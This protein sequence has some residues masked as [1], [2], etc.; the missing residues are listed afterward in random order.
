MVVN[1]RSRTCQLRTTTVPTVLS[2]IHKKF[3]NISNN[4]QKQYYVVLSGCV[5]ST[6]LL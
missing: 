2:Y 3:E 1:G 6:N 4:L 5:V